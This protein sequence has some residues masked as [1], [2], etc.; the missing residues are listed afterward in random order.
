MDKLIE[1]DAALGEYLVELDEKH[2]YDPKTGKS[3][4]PA[5]Q[6]KRMQDESVE[7]IMK[8][9]R[10]RRTNVGQVLDNARLRNRGVKAP[11]SKGNARRRKEKGMTDQRST[12]RGRQAYRRGRPL[13]QGSI[14]TIESEQAYKQRRSDAKEAKKAS[15]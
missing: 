15:K 13:S 7:D 5:H 2:G 10:G 11:L 6:K 9:K 1:L 12:F 4:N 3:L 14:D 8:G